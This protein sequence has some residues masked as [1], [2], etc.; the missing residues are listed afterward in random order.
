MVKIQFFKWNSALIFLILS[1]TNIFGTEFKD[2][3][4]SP[5]DSTKMSIEIIDNHNSK[6][7]LSKV[8]HSS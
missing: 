5:F 6:N 4:L 7:R 8:F 3:D 1:I 2:L